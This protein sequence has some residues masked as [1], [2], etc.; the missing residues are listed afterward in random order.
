[1][2]YQPFSTESTSYI[3][4]FVAI[5]KL[6][7]PLY[8]TFIQPPLYFMLNLS[9]VFIVQPF[10]R[11]HHVARL[12]LPLLRH[13]PVGGSYIGQFHCITG[14]QS[15]QDWFSGSS[16]EK[17]R[18]K[19]P[20]TKGKGTDFRPSP[21]RCIR[22][23]CQRPALHFVTSKEARSGTISTS[24]ANDPM[25]IISM[26]FLFVKRSA[27]ICRT[28]IKNGSGKGRNGCTKFLPRLPP[29]LPGIAP[30]LNP[31]TSYSPR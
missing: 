5:K 24:D 28:F 13:T 4:P 6:V 26:L 3:L 10:L 20:D 9:N 22:R 1:M 19:T 16:H 18:F 7:S 29:T 15:D 17:Q 27:F 12:G 30:M 31:A 11:R 23:V 25:A 21:Y 8:L 14:I 2:R